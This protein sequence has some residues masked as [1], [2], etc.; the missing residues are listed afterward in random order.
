LPKVIGQLLTG[1][2]TENDSQWS[3]LSTQLNFFL[4]LGTIQIASM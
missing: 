1:Y 3:P 4:S 2:H